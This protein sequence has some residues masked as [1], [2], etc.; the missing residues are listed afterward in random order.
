MKLKEITLDRDMFKKWLEAG[1]PRPILCV[2]HDTTGKANPDEWLVYTVE[3]MTVAGFFDVR[4][5]GAYAYL[6]VVP[7]WWHED[8]YQVPEEKYLA[9]KDLYPD[10]G[11]RTVECTPEQAIEAALRRN[12]V[13][14]MYMWADDVNNILRLACRAFHF[15]R[16]KFDRK[17]A[18]VQEAIDRKRRYAVVDARG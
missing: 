4:E 8:L 16:M 13:D 12:E 17:I 10:M 3:I 6:G 14:K 11:V 2:G 9:E 15:E 7:V 5:Y 1:V 18:S